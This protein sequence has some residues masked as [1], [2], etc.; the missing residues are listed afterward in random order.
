MSAIYQVGD[1]AKLVTSATDGVAGYFKTNPGAS[2][3]SAAT[4]LGV[5]YEVVYLAI[6]QLGL[7][8]LPSVAG[9]LHWP[10]QRH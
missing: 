2:I 3:E 5:P 6:T 10:A 7:I 9:E 1:I 4:A 8:V